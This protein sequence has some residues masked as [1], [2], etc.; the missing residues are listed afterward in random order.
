[1]KKLL[2]AQARQ[3]RLWYDVSSL[4]PEQRSEW[5]D[6]L[7]LGL[8]EEV[9]ELA[10]QIRTRAHVKPE[11]VPGGNVLAE[12]VD[13]LKYLLALSDLRGISAEELERAFMEKTEAVT[14]RYRQR[15]LELTEQTCVLVTDLDG[16]VADA[17]PFVER[18]GAY[19][20]EKGSGLEREQAVSEW[21]ESGGFLDLEVVAGARETLAEARSNGCLIAIVTARP[22]WAHRRVYL[23]TVGWLRKHGI[24]YDILVFEKDKHDALIRHVL[25]ARVIGFVEDRDKHAIELAA[26][27]IPVLLMDYPWNR[28][29]VPAPHPFIRRVAGWTEIRE[30]LA[31][32][33]WK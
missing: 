10:R 11:R 18:F 4:T 7:L 12:T 1:M 9:G 17:L 2:E 6:E 13:V 19:H 14:A 23:D 5:T 33:E 28:N 3:Q 25:P 22:Q 24:E 21:Y 15:H 30:H 27:N 31:S 16:C 8:Y 32:K 26:H 29:T 20:N